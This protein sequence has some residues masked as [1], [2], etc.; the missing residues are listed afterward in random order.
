MPE[1]THF[2]CE[3][4][5]D[6]KPFQIRTIVRRKFADR[7]EAIYRELGYDISHRQCGDPYCLGPEPIEQ[8]T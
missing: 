7:E 5:I 3:R 2:E 4:R 1:H 6:G 8:L